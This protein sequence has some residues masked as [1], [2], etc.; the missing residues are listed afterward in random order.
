MRVRLP[1][2]RA[3]F[4]AAAFLFA[5]IALVPMRLAVDWIGLGER[6]FAAREAKG[7][8][9]LGAFSEAQ[10]GSV[11]LG[12][13]KA[14][15]NTLPLLLGRARV[16]L[17]RNSE[18]NPFEGAATVTGDGFG[19]HDLTAELPVGPVFAPLP[20]STL[21]LSDVTAHFSGGQ[22]AA[23][24]GLVRA[25][26]AGDLGGIALGSGLSGDARCDRAP[27]CFRSPASR[28]WKG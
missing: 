1:V 21:D 25:N 10:F 14:E 9:W 3:L 19:L 20:V 23:A 27:C 17:E 12:N 26:V 8:V 4:F 5:L 11:P 22:C 15:L 7:S 18:G 28:G 24:E 6:G 16:S 2:G 13:L